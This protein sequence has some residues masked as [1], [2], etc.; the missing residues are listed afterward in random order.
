ADPDGAQP[1]L[2]GDH[3]PVLGHPRPPRRPRRDRLLGDPQLRE[4]PAAPDRPHGPPDRSRPV[5]QRAH[6]GEG[7][8]PSEIAEQTLAAMGDD[9]SAEVVVTAGC[10]AL[11]RFANSF[12]HQNI[13]QDTATVEL[14]VEVDGRV[15][16]SSATVAEP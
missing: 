16:S 11:T 8:N 10:T 6:G 7:M 2:Y 9:V 4:G 12:I 1:H 5:L 15:S 14:R 3:P 13:T